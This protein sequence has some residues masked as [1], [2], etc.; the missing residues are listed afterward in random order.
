MRRTPTYGDGVV[1][2]K[3]S[4]LE[5]LSTRHAELRIILQ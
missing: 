2:C 1:C 4:V 3:P 5:S